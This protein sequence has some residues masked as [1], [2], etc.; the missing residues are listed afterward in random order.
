MLGESK[1]ETQQ[2]KLHIHIMMSDAKPLFRSP[3]PV[4]F[5][6]GNI[7]LSLGLVPHPILGFSW[8]ISH[9]SG[10]SSILGSPRQPRLHL[11]SF[12]QW[13]PLGLRAGPPLTYV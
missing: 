4:G 3:T 8:Q 6:D 1:I 2:D 10:I 7:L 13:H 5:V 9:G 12:T 11:Q